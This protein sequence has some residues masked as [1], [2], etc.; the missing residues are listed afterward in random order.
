MHEPKRINTLKDLA[1]VAHE[2]KLAAHP[3]VPPHAVPKTAY[4]DKDTNGLTKAVVDFLNIQPRVFAWRVNNGAVYDAS[5]GKHRSAATIRG[6]ADVCAICE[7]MAWQI[8]IKAGKDRL[9]G[10]QK[11][12]AARVEAAGGRYCV[13]RTF[14]G[15]AAEWNAA[16]QP[17]TD[18]LADELAAMFEAMG[19][20]VVDC[21]HARV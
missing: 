16:R 15:F 7:G 21:S 20:K 11:G 13:A 14:E 3:T 12:F 1:A 10:H 2:R 4:T 5:I 19:A 17:K 6:V 18:P 9:S 8:E